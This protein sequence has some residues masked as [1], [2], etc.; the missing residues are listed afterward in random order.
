MKRNIK[1]EQFNFVEYG[2]NKELYYS[3]KFKKWK[4]PWAIS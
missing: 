2:V 3:K 4:L 1:L